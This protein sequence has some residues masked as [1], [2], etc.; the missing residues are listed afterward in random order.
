MRT[1]TLG[2]SGLVV[3]N[4][5]LGLMRIKDKS[6]AQIR[7]LVSTALDEG[8]TMF[9]HAD[10]YGTDHACEAR[11]G[12]ALG[13][14]AAEREQVVLQTKCGIRFGWFD[15]SEKHILD[16]VDGSLAA[17]RT[18][19]IDVL[20][21]HRPD[22]LVEPEEVASA[23]DRL[24]A[25][26]KVRHFGV[27]NHTRG[28][29]E[30]LRAT[31][32]QPLLA[33]Q[34]QL[35]L[36]HGHMIA[37]GVAQNMQHEQSVVRTDGVLDYCRLTSTTVQAWSPYQSGDGSGPFIGNRERYAELNDVLDRLAAGYGVSP[38]AVA[39]AWI[40]RHPANMQVVL[41]TTRPERVR[42][43]AAGSELGLGR[44]EWYELFR[45]AGH[46]VP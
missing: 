12:R 30:L 20:L 14:S 5:V 43:A 23:F 26:G 13:W 33:N 36:T 3:P 32:D 25:S 15:F 24:S 41:G 27:S 38:D 7:E 28:Q 4:I 17:L 44:E 39:A 22:A 6:D 31:V 45:A 37:E 29:L 9:D 35:S 11:A 1:F 42:A 2:T 46:I 34:L 16:S 8:I 19:Y 40:T 10:I 18:D 21:L